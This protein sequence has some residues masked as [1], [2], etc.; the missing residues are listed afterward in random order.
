MLICPVRTTLN[1]DDD[2]YRHVKAF[3]ALSGKSVTSVVEE[4]L[5]LALQQAQQGGA[6][7]PMPV[8]RADGG[9]S[10]EFRESGIDVND[11]SAVLEMLD[12]AD[13]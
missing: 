1:I 4:S 11:T 5:R 7:A 10:R 3:A 13:A 6:I 12:R 8:S 9:L 2:L